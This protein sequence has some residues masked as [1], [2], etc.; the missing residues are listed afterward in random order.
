ME[1]ARGK[2]AKFLQKQH[3]DAKLEGNT[4]VYSPKRKRMVKGQVPIELPIYYVFNTEDSQGYVIVSADDRTDAILGYAT[5]GR[6]DADEIPKNVKA[7]MNSYAEQIAALDK[8][9]QETTVNSQQT[10][11]IVHNL[12]QSS[13]FK[14]QS[15]EFK[16]QSS[17]VETSPLWRLMVA[18]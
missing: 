5:A 17:A 13:K 9:S 11:D 18:H 3:P 8:Y 4:P 16:V 12:V 2:A 1:Q 6:F 10:T 15:S 14:V 7:W